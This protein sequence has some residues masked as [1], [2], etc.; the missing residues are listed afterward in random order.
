MAQPVNPADA[1]RALAEI[2]RR[3]RQ[4]IAQIDIPAWYWWGL[5]LGWVALGLVTLADMP[6]LSVAATVGFGVLHAVVA[7]RVM[8]G[9]HG[10]RQLSVR[11]DV[12]SRHV[13]SLV[14]A[15][16]LVLVAITIVIALVADALGAPQPVLIASAAV[17]LLV[18]VGGPRLMALV[19]HRAARSER[20]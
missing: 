12:V 8:D 16:L 2:E 13:R 4:I 6:W 11:A 5:A 18:L 3:R 15:F 17:A 9:R 14:I 19:R 1:G 7:A 20:G 10:S